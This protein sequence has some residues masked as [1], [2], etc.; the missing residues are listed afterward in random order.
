MHF[1]S[2]ILKGLR[3]MSFFLVGSTNPDVYLTLWVIQTDGSVAFVRE[4][5]HPSVL[6]ATWIEH[7]AADSYVCTNETA[8]TISRFNLACDGAS[9]V[10][11]GHSADSSDGGSPTHV[12]VSHD[13]KKVFVSNYHGGSLSIF[14]YEP[15]GQPVLNR[16][17][18]IHHNHEGSAM[19]AHVHQSVVNRAADVLYVCDLGMDSVC[20]YSL[21]EAHSL[22]TTLQLPTGTGPRHA[23]VTRCGR[24][25]CIVCE[26]SNQLV[27]ASIDQRTGSA[28]ECGDRVY[29]TLPEGADDGEMGAAEVLLSIDGRFLYVSNRDV[30]SPAADG[31]APLC[32]R[33]SV[34]VFCL[35]A[36]AGTAQLVQCVSSRGRHP[37]HMSFAHGGALLVVANRDSQSFAAFPV[38]ANS[39]LLNEAGAVV[40]PCG[41]HCRDPGF[42]LP[43]DGDAATVR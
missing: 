2:L 34:S 13:H 26:L 7:V 12:A 22:L 29:S 8:G 39:G 4:F 28:V 36:A 41:P 33:S 20:T 43:V 30:R 19:A 9:H 31:T 5:N 25:L 35:D 27:V 40:S 14:A 10:F 37:R 11:H 38:D 21:D 18:T 3:E 16:M 6:N 23:V 24:W 42:L 15:T 1:T 32:E 17:R